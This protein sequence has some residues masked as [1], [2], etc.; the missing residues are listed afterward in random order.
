MNNLTGKDNSL[1]ELIAEN[2]PRLKAFIRK[3][4]DLI[5]KWFTPI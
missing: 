2:Q 1:E 4:V 5:Q 3:R